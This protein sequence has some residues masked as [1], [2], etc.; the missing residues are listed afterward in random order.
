MHLFSKLFVEYQL[1]AN[2]REQYNI[3]AFTELVFS[4]GGIS[5]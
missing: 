5:Q 2:E 3:P 4:R 1:Y